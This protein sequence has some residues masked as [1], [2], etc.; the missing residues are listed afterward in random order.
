MLVWNIL[1]V[2]A[3]SFECPSYT[4]GTSPSLNCISES[5][6]SGLE[7]FS[8]SPCEIDLLCPINKT[9]TEQCSAFPQ[10]TRYP[11]EYCANDWDCIS[12]LCLSNSC[13]GYPLGK[14]CAKNSDCREGLYCSSTSHSCVNQI[15][16]GATCTVTDP[17]VNY[18]LCQD[19]VCIEMFS[20][21]IGN[22]TEIVESNGWAPL[23]PQG[24]A[25]TSNGVSVCDVTAKINILSPT[26]CTF[27]TNCSDSQGKV[28]VPCQ[29]GLDGNGYCPLFVENLLVQTLITQWK[30]IFPVNTQGCHISN[31]WS[32]AC[33]ISLAE[34]PAELAPY[35]SW[36]ILSSLFFNDTW[37]LNTSASSCI[38]QSVIPDFYNLNQQLI[39]PTYQCPAYSC[40]NSIFSNNP[41]QCV[42]TFKN[43]Y[44]S[45]LATIVKLYQCNSTSTCQAN[46]TLNSTCIEYQNLKLYPGQ[47]C[48]D[49]TQCNNG[50][51]ENSICQGIARNAAC[52]STAN[53]QPGDFCYES[54]CREAGNVGDI[55]NET[56]LCKIGNLCDSV[57]CV[58]QFSLENG[59]ET[60]L[61]PENSEAGFA[62]SCISGFAS[63][64]NA[65]VGVCAA[66]AHSTSIPL[67][68]V[69]QTCKSSLA[70]Y[71]KS[72]ECGLN[73]LAFCPSFEGDQYLVNAIKNFNQISGVDCNYELGLS[74][75]CYGK[76]LQRL[77][78]FYYYRTNLT[79]Y[80]NLP[81]LQGNTECLNQGF[82][83]EYWSDLKMI[84]II[85]EEMAHDHSFSQYL[86][87]F[88]LIFLIVSN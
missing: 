21:E 48:T 73:G 26:S 7:V 1:L 79:Y 28:S 46:P 76:D 8:V 22:T 82:M 45:R 19:S 54:F 24:F 30:G 80:E 20:L 44:S 87:A 17:C 4:C 74:P 75:G 36:S 77:L 63:G 53:C 85:I 86:S 72:C 9:E 43:I 10:F 70:N 33:F 25:N 37:V 35:T 15:P 58:R 13:R 29:C 40:E 11:G 64:I 57:T 50:R 38:Q 65:G 83:A 27:G 55:C 69:G 23:C 61:V 78:G 66:S 34:T 2:F 3:S 41:D 59:Q 32:Y 71:T 16:V 39:N 81:L 52:I 68:L 12:N 60:A 84:E 62:P 5:S 67:C 42:N 14:T 49:G 56:L 6:E 47:N 31:P 88:S 51:C 18:A